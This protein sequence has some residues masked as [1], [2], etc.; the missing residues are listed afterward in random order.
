VGTVVE[1]SGIPLGNST[2]SVSLRQTAQGRYKVTLKL[3]RP[4]VQT[5]TINGISTPTVVRTNRATV[6]FDLDPASST[7]ERTDLE[8]MLADSL[9]AGKPLVFGSVVNL[10]GVF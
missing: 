10:E 8:G 2:Y 4:V 5:Q 7:Q 1:S 6:E 3:S 9:G